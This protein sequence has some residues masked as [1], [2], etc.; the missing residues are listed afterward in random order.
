[1]VPSRIA[2]LKAPLDSYETAALEN[3]VHDPDVDGATLHHVFVT[4]PKQVDCDLIK[5]ANILPSDLLTIWNEHMCR[6]DDLIPNPQTPMDVVKSI[7][8][9]HHEADSDPNILTIRDRAAIR[10]AKEACDPKLLYSLFNARADFPLDTNAGLKMRTQ[11]VSNI[12][13]PLVVRAQ[14]KRMPDLKQPAD[15]ERYYGNLARGNQEAGEAQYWVPS[16]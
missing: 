2:N 13:T 8:D 6:E 9:S 4:F 11:M 1:M 7:F 16:R 10:I 15:Y 3:R 14:M 12:C 5:N